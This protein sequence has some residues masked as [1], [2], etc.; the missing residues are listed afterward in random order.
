MIFV[1]F[2]F[3]VL[4]ALFC[5][6]LFCVSGDNISQP[7][8]QRSSSGPQ[9]E[10]RTLLQASLESSIVISSQLLGQLFV[11]VCENL[12]WVESHQALASTLLI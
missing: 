11:P 4:F 12:M 9:P 8:T 3:F 7:T 5:C 1:L 10:Q 6:V 2:L